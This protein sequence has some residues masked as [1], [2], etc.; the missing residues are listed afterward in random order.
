MH[1]A[2]RRLL[3]LAALPL[4]APVSPGSAWAAGELNLD[5]AGL[6]LEGYDPV[7][8][9]TRGEPTPG[10]AGI[11]TQFR[12]ATYLFASQSHLAM[13]QADPDRYLPRYGGYCAYAAALGTKAHGD[14]E[15]WKI[16]D[17]RLYLNYSRWIGW[18]WEADQAA[19]I[20][21]ADKVWPRIA[22]IPADQLE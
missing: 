15:V 1:V 9:V 22:A 4:L 7:A 21:K 20:A 19:Y 6:A 10:E 14:P 3:A 5:D 2:R 13:F 18:R 17:G 8:Y 11:T 16:V 12:G